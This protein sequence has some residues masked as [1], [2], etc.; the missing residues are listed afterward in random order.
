MHYQKIMKFK[1]LFISIL[2]IFALLILG[3][4]KEEGYGGN[5]HIK[6]TLIEHVYNDNYSQ[7]IYEKKGSE[8]DIY[9]TFE[10]NDIV[11][12]KVTSG[13]DGDFK[14]EYLFPGNYQIYYYSDDTSSAYSDNIQVII[15]IKLGKNETVDL[16]ELIRINS[17]AY[18]EGSAKIKGRVF[19]INYLNSSTYPNLIVKDTSLAL[20]QEI[21]LI[22]G[23]HAS[24]DDRIR[25]NYDGSFFFGNLI[26]GN[27]KVFLY[28]EDI[29]GKTED[30]VIMRDILITSEFEEIDL[31]DIYIEQL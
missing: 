22:F 7:I 16:G 15:D 18:N 9:I 8:E 17:I 19:L 4:T 26:K 29:S 21:Y 23:N 24:Y 11:N 30:I 27:Y 12:D 5:S 28:S 14:F 6:G 10:N 20:D 25:T 31:G 1:T 2:S 13:Y 3:C